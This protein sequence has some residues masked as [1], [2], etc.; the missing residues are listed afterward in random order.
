MKTSLVR[1]TGTTH[2]GTAKRGTELP[3]A[4]LTEQATIEI[5]ALHAAKQHAIE[6]LNRE[7]SIAG[8]SKKFG[9]HHRTIERVLM[10]E[11]WPHTLKAES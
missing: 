6:V 8:L 7:F 4:K 9:V 11:T 10:R 5:R 2:H 1:H 3:H